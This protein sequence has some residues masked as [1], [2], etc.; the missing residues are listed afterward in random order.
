MA[1]DIIRLRYFMPNSK[2][3]KPQNAL[4]LESFK[5]ENDA[6]PPGTQPVMAGVVL[7]PVLF[8]IQRAKWQ[9]DT[10][11]HHLHPNFQ[12]SYGFR[13]FRPN[14]HGSSRFKEACKILYCS[15]HSTWFY[16]PRHLM[17]VKAVLVKNAPQSEVKW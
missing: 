8:Q 3:S 5:S 12:M 17:S 11:P 9:V 7:W 4:C 16:L 13:P 14:K 1:S 15:I 6:L 10:T 2:H